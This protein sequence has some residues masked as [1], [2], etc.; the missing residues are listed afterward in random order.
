MSISSCLTANQM[1]KLPQHVQLLLALSQRPT[2]KTHAF[3]N[4][5]VNRQSDTGPTSEQR[6]YAEIMSDPFTGPHWGKGYDE[7]VREGWTESEDESEDSGSSGLDDEVLTPSGKPDRLSKRA[8]ERLQEAIRW[9]DAQDR[10]RRAWAALENIK[11]EQYWK[12]TD[13]CL[14]RLP[15]GSYGWRDLTTGRLLISSRTLTLC[16]IQCLCDID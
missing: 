7:E 5:Y 1:T 16:S 6:L 12:T 15:V 14:E 2:S 11:R 3:A 9:E 10:S 8:E 4:A 13:E